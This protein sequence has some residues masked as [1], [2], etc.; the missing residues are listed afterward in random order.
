M[1]LGKAE[2]RQRGG[3]KDEFAREIEGFAV[4]GIRGESLRPAIP[5]LGMTGAGVPADRCALSVH[6]LSVCCP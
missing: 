3:E 2:L 4:V 6:R 5:L 1:F